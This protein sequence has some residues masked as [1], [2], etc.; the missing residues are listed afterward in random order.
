MISYFFAPDTNARA[1]RWG[2]VVE[3]WRRNGHEVD[4]IT[5]PQSG[6]ARTADFHGATVHHVG[7]RMGGWLRAALGVQS[8]ATGSRTGG[9]PS[10]GTLSWAKGIARNVHASTWRRIYWPDH[11]AP[12]IGSARRAAK[13]L[14]RDRTFDALIT[15][16]HP[17]SSHVVGLEIKRAFPKLIWLAD[18]G[19]PFSFFEEI[20]INN[21]NLYRGRNHRV[22][23]RVIEHADVLSVT[24]ESCKLAYDE[25][26][27]RG[28]G[29]TVVIPPLVAGSG[30]SAV[31][32]TDAPFNLVYVGTLYR[33]IRNPGYL[34]RLL[35]A[36]PSLALD[37]YGDTNDCTEQFRALPP[38]VASR[39]TLHG[40]VA[41]LAAR[42][43]M[44][45]AGTLVN[46]GNA[47]RHQ[48][49]SKVFEYIATGRP[50]L[51]LVGGDWDS[52][53]PFLSR[54]RPC[55][56]VT[57]SAAGPSD[58][59]CRAIVEWLQEVR[60]AEEGEVERLLSPNRAPAVAQAYLDTLSPVR[61]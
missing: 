35:E 60:P 11:A 50:I 49:P 56:T 18:S 51:N 28:I 31:G 57:M 24:V 29:K 55:L 53:S 1:L 21:L 15:V 54:Y 38:A 27:P 3:E 16:S 14:I 41:P 23:G 20:P 9:R 17:F 34:L 6:S 40:T 59:D 12:W 8:A 22:E 30:Y 25:T 52:S 58:R 19:D 39:V 44:A 36:V 32:R 2:R 45:A 33:R 4:V 13:A 7:G 43:A 48:L 42:Q 26:F 46:I 61:P 5:R 10:P 37:I 47:T